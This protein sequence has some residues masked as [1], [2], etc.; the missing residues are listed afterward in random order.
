M[1][2]ELITFDCYGTLVDWDA[3]IRS[4]FMGAAARDG[5]TL[6]GDRAL[7]AYHAI[8]PRIETGPYRPYRDVL[9]TVGRR[10][11]ARLGWTPAPGN[12]NFLA[13]ALPSWAPFPET[14]RSLARL[15]GDGYRLGVLS[16]IDD[17]LLAETLRHFTVAF[18]L[19]V[20]AQQL[21]SYKPA[22]A[23]F[24]RA[25][26]EVDGDRGRLLHVAASYY[27]DVRPAREMGIATVWVDRS[28]AERPEEGP[29]PTAEAGDLDEAVRW[30]EAASA[31][32]DGGA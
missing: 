3:G 21:E 23:H 10:V 4:A 18:D 5:V 31:A 19:I 14:N 20:T 7:E 30:I 28:G 6:D 26:E 1:R 11:A 9:A 8:E 24:E 17:D 12:E 22:R 27:H 13:D 2:P 25:L 15:D 32:G 16:N 29:E